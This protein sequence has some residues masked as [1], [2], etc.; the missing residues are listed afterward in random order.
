MKRCCAYL[1]IVGV[2]GAVGGTLP[3][4]EAG[5]VAI[6][7]NGGKRMG[8]AFSGGAAEADDA[9][10]IWWNP[11][12]MTRLRS[13]QIVA[14][15]HLILPDVSYSDDGSLDLTGGAMLGG[16]GGNGGETAVVPN[17][18]ATWRLNRRAVVGLGVNAPY[19]LA[20]D[21]PSDWIGRYFATRSEIVSV[22]INP[23][24][25]YKLNRQW[26]VG[27]GL[28]LSHIDASIGNQVDF[29]AFAGMPQAMDGSVEITGEDWGLGW[30][31]GVLFEPDCCTR[32]G[33]HYRSRIRHTLDGEGDFTV[34]GALAPV[35]TRGGRFVDSDA[36]ADIELPDTLSFSAYRKLNRRLAVMGDI[37]WTRWSTFDELVVKFAN[38]AEP[39]NVLDLD[40][41][42]T[43][44]ASLGAT[45]QLTPRIQLR[46]GVMFDEGAAIT[47]NRTPRVPDNDRFWITAGVGVQLSRALRVDLSY[48]HIEVADAKVR[49]PLV[50]GMRGS[51]TGEIATSIDILGLQVTIDF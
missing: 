45:Y 30:N 12:G 38:P 24:V 19:G 46:A 7:E 34:P 18:F 11:A 27:A 3:G 31:A 32:L 49:Q 35:V 37:T 42:N 47:E 51:L 48:A 33:L 36:E 4:A 44:R 29:G 28:N 8:N 17:L 16:L 23:S 21:Y 25:A 1:V 39:D 40:W 14:A 22:N 15:A 9:S 20:T 2:L 41:Q 26:S 6:L 50:P 5:G 43:I 13:R 10:T